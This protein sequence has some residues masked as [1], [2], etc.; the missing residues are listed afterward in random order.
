MSSIARRHPLASTGP[1]REGGRRE[2]VDPRRADPPTPPSHR[3]STTWHGGLMGKAFGLGRPPH[4]AGLD[5]H[6]PQERS[7]EGWGKRGGGRR[8]RFAEDLVDE[9]T[10]RLINPNDE[11][12]VRPDVPHPDRRPPAASHRKWYARR[13]SSWSS[14][15]SSTVDSLSS[16][17]TAAASPTARS[18]PTSSSQSSVPTLLQPLDNVQSY[19][20]LAAVGF[21]PFPPLA[22]QKSSRDMLERAY[23]VL[24]STRLSLPRLERVE[25][26]A[27]ADWKERVKT[28][29]SL[30][31]SLL[32]SCVVVH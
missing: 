1:E 21:F 7:S 22:P 3:R 32:P 9:Q 4:Q 15:G 8:A 25:K 12:L 27:S 20:K 2:Q 29:I 30:S 19:V 17:W 23:E 31:L 28:C 6:S 5:S 11:P 16:A 18:H 26:I 10:E 13:S 24:H 14:S